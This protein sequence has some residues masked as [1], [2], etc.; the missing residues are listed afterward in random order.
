MVIMSYM[1]IICVFMCHF[2]RLLSTWR[3][4]IDNLP[5]T[6][7]HTLWSTVLIHFL[8]VFNEHSN[9]KDE[10]EI[11]FSGFWFFLSILSHC[12]ELFQSR[13]WNKLMN[14]VGLKRGKR[15]TFFRLLISQNLILLCVFIKK[16]LI[17]V[18]FERCMIYFTLI[19][20]S[21]RWVC[22]ILKVYL[23]NIY[24]I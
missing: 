11:Y 12:N 8:S 18:N 15:N 13:F 1:V 19:D 20:L 7:Q 3:K 22:Y 6:K 2:I 4:Y 9:Y 23:W 17:N 10:N 16:K 14:S 24:C 21:Y 5:H